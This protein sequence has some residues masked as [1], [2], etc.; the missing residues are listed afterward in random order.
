MEMSTMSPLSLL[1]SMAQVEFR[2]PWFL[3][4]AL[5]AIPVLLLARRTGGRVLFSSFRLI[6]ST[7]RSWRMR[8]AWIPD[9]LVALAAAALGLALAG[10]RVGHRESR[11]RREGIAIMMVADISGSM[12]ALDLSGGDRERTRLD[13]VREVFR[14][15][16]EGGAGLAGRPDDAIGLVSFARYAD[17]RCPLTLDHSNLLAVADSLAIVEDRDEDG[18]AIGDG[19][20]LAV[21]RLRE[22]PVKSRVVIL[23]TDGVNNAGQE[24]P[25][26][27]AELARTQRVKVYTVGAGTD[28]LAPV[29]VEDP[30]TGGTVLRAMQVE[31]DEETLQAIAERTGGKYFRATDSDALLR[32]YQ[33]ID[34][35]ERTEITE[36]KF[37]EYNEY[38]GFFTGLGL[39]L[40]AASWLARGTVFR[41]LP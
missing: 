32:V 24:S 41:R 15:F 22:S 3:L 12:R 14:Q 8:L 40:A 39:L 28:G 31:I 16:V 7:G 25:L 9:V 6:P 5:S 20:G 17:T 30:F 34:R 21:E 27:A 37:R 18:T 33:E 10:P 35:L 38:Y 26:A 29:R 4:A 11:V 2:H 23:L 36:R 1:H 13:A 19:L